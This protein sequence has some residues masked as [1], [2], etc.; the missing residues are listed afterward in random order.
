[1]LCHTCKRMHLQLQLH[2]ILRSMVNC[3]FVTFLNSNSIKL[4]MPP[5]GS[6]RAAK[7]APTPAP[8]RSKA[9]GKAETAEKTKKRKSN[10]KEEDDDGPLKV[11]AGFE[12]KK[13]SFFCKKTSASAK[14]SATPEASA[15]ASGSTTPDVPRGD[16]IDFDK[17]CVAAKNGASGWKELLASFNDREKSNLVTQAVD[18]KRFEEHWAQVAGEERADR[19]LFGQE[20][21]P[22]F[23]EWLFCASPTAGADAAVK[24][25]SDDSA[26][27]AA[28]PAEQPSADTHAE[29][30][31]PPTPAEPVEFNADAG[32][33]DGDIVVPKKPSTMLRQ[34][35]VI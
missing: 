28:E 21:L 12:Y 34:T 15:S 8:K 16:Q 23:I 4:A 2:M 1:M 7:P 29:P 14:T 18:H 30:N 27:N 35:C 9:K 25:P 32:K 19:R 31:A 17:L 11:P 33:T 6:K 5:K 22:G 26:K 13:L 3:F 20:D 24:Q 10:A